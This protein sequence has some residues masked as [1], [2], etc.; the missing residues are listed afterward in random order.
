MKTPGE[1]YYGSDGDATR[2]LYK[3]LDKLGPVGVVA[4][5]L[6]RAC[7]ASERAKKYRGGIR[8]LGRYKDMAYEKKQWSMNN[9]CSALTC[10]GDSLGIRFGWK[11]DPDQ[12]AKGDP[13]VWVL[14][15]DLPTGQVSFHTAGRGEGPDYP[16]DWDHSPKS[17]ERIIAWTSMLLLEASHG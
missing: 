9:L 8:G 7:K 15:V 1:V 6:M 13:H 16:G 2:E 4:M 17:A 11:K 14:Y 3:E 12:E 5:N 10:N